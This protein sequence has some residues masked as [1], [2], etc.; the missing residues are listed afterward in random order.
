[1]A[2]DVVVKSSQIVGRRHRRMVLQQSGP[3][4]DSR[5]AAIQFNI[6]P[7]QR[8]PDFFPRMAYRLRW[9]RWNGSR[10]P[11]LLIEEI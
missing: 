11:Q 2:R 7:Q 6:D 1:M 4:A 10:T 5:L 3:D 8:Q 9:N